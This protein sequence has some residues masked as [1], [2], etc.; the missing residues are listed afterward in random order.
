MQCH[1]ASGQISGGNNIMHE[2]EPSIHGHGKIVRYKWSPK[3]GVIYLILP[4]LPL[5]FNDGSVKPSNQ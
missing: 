3:T 4:K 5:N 2:T 1:T